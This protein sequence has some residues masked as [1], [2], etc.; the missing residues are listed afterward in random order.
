MG[1]GVLGRRLD[2]RR[3]GLG[4]ADGDIIADRI[5]EENSILR[6]QGDLL[7]QIL[8]GDLPNIGSAN[9][10]RSASRIVKPQE[11]IG[12]AC[13]SRA[14]FSYQRNHLRFYDPRSG[15]ISIGGTDI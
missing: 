7:A 1:I 9:G 5:V 2:F 11:E 13:F 10:N 14:T 6:D 4:P 12:E 15:S 8:S 3:R